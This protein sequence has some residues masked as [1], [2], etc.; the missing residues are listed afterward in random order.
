M[1]R[2]F[3]L[4]A[5]IAVLAATAPAA[6]TAMAAP[7]AL[8]TPDF[9]TAAAQTDEYERQA[10]RLASRKGHAPKVRS[11][12]E[13]MVRDHTATTAALKAAIRRG[14]LPQPPPP[15]LSADQ[16]QMVNQLTSAKADFDASYAAQQVQ[17]HQKALA[18]MR[19]Y[20]AGGSNASLR[21]AAAKTAPLVEHHLM[22]ARA[23]PTRP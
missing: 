12:G 5:A 4:P 19:A 22:L 8:A 1:F 21:A 7:A 3:V 6:F 16:Q 18:V 15:S 17:A 11:F 10:G 9:I 14:G 20:A 13:M 23:L 2:T